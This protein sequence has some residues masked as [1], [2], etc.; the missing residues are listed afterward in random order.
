MRQTA[1]RESRF[2][3]YPWLKHEVIICRWMV[4]LSDADLT[5]RVRDG[6]RY[7]AEYL[8]HSDRIDPQS[9]DATEIRGG[10]QVEAERIIA[11]GRNAM[12]SYMCGGLD[13]YHIN[14][15]A[16]EEGVAR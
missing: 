3:P 7:D 15:V 6:K 1:T 11:R 14:G 13:D 10:M 2:R 12:L 16:A 8:I 4:H 9:S 5:A